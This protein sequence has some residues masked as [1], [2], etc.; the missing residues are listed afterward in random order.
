MA[1][2]LGVILTILFMIRD[3]Y[4]IN[5]AD[6]ASISLISYAD[7]LV[8]IGI[9]LTLFPIWDFT[10]KAVNINEQKC[11]LGIFSAALVVICLFTLIGFSVSF[12]MV[13]MSN[14]EQLISAVP[15]WIFDGYRIMLV[16]ALICSLGYTVR[17]EVVK[18]RK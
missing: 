13:I 9:S 8:M 15:S 5:G 6:D 14:R 3:V 1:Q 4:N 10:Q 17:M 16:G 18:L 11:C 12:G 7:R 2:S